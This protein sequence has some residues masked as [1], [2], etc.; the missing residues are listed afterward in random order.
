MSDTIL[1]TGATG[2]IGS[3]VAPRLVAGGA[4]V[5][6][7]VRDPVKAAP[8]E[9]A[10]VE[11]AVGELE[12]PDSVARAMAGIH[13]LLLITAPGPMA[14][15]QADAAI[16]A[17]EKAGV[18]RIVRIS[19]IQNDER[20]ASDN[21]RQHMVTDARILRSGIPYTILR[22][23]FFMQNIFMSVPTIASEGKMVW[24]MGD[25]KLAFVDVRD[26]VDM[27]VKVTLEKGHENRIYNVCGPAALTFTEAAEVLTK[28]LGRPITYVAVPPAAVEE[29]L[30]AMGMGDWFP[31]VMR[32]YSQ[33]Y[34]ENWGA[35]LSG[36]TQKVL[37]HP[38]RSFETFA[39][40]VFAP[41]LKQPAA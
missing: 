20:A 5:R 19:V 10:G 12:K 37:G 28:V 31:K 39:R 34:S 7:F 11:L 18:K 21:V 22:P 26:I 25:G 23:N 35:P 27:A 3:Q 17:A 4:K 14:S 1:I 36:D 13:T 24:G 30:K 33:A 29:S 40:E 16:A 2:S 41:A 8:L 15:V 38:A 6:A 9:K 32:D